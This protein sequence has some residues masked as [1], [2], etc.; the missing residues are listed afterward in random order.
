[1]KIELKKI[2]LNEEMSEESYCFSADIYINGIKSGVARNHGHGGPT[3]CVSYNA[4]GKKIINE[5]ETYCK[6][7]PPEEWEMDG[8]KISTPM[9]LETCINDL[10]EKHLDKVQLQK[11]HKTLNQKS[12]KSIVYGIPPESGSYEYKYNYY[13]LKKPISE[14]IVQPGGLVSLANF[15]RDR[16]KSELTNGVM[17]LNNNIPTAVYK[18]AGLD[19]GVYTKRILS[20]KKI[21]NKM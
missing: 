13:T 20:P 2:D 17:I 11:I 4:Q 21:G 3:S 10:L 9:E 15:I 6:S 7:L 12:K 1:M 14:I 16:V 8:E 18:I 19:E 5:A